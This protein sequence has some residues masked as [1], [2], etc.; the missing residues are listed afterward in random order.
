MPAMRHGTKRLT[1]ANHRSMAVWN[2]LTVLECI[3]REA[4][5]S[6][7][8]IAETYGMQPSTVS[9]VIRELRECGIVREAGTLAATGVGAKQVS[10]EI[11]AS[12]AWVACW[13]IDLKGNSLCLLDAAGHIV[14]QETLPTDLGWR[15]IV[16]S[17]RERISAL[18]DSRRLPMSRFAGLG[19]CVQGIVNRERGEVIYSH[20][21]EMTEVPLRDMLQVRLKAPVYVE[22]NVPC[23]A[24]LEQHS[25]AK[26]RGKSFLYYLIQRHEKFLVHGAGIVLSGEVFRGSHSAAG[27]L[28]TDFFREHPDFQRLKSEKDWDRLY[29]AESNSIAML[30]DFLDVDLV[31]VSSDD[32][33]LT[34]RRFQTLQKDVGSQIRPI[35]G[36]VVEII[37]SSSGPE[38]ML[39]GGG[40]IALHE[41]FLR[42][43]ESLPNRSVRGAA[44][45]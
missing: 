17:I 26:A 28:T 13:R 34:E 12:F 32:P 25:T 18:A 2:S 43:A 15:D 1:G 22:R 24:Y 33:A 9:N 19:V 36:R 5:I 39:V 45:S 20:P 27:E 21:L 30:A 7:R 42:V 16:E 31:I 29:R 11:D 10:L 14:A 4:H 44:R 8:Q 37:R 38:G 41:Y 35:K 23:G 6:Q 3:L 40:L